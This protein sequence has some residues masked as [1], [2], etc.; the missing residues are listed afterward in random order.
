MQ[1]ST[2]VKRFRCKFCQNRCDFFFLLFLETEAGLYD[3]YGEMSR[4]TSVIMSVMVVYDS[5]RTELVCN[6]SESIH[7]A[8]TLH[9]RMNMVLLNMSVAHSRRPI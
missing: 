3:W 9:L 2:Q 1:Y 7:M 8:M 4:K 5:K 6:G